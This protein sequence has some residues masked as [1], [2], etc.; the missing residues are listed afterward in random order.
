[1][2]RLPTLPDPWPDRQARLVHAICADPCPTPPGQACVN[3]PCVSGLTGVNGT[4]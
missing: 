4:I 1:M 3:F 2:G